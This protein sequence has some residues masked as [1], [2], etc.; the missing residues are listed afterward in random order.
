MDISYLSRI[1]LELVSWS[2]HHVVVTYCVYSIGVEIRHG[3]NAGEENSARAIKQWLIMSNGFI[4][5]AGKPV[6]EQFTCKRF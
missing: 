5:N 2:G 6:S 1:R 3:G 4:N